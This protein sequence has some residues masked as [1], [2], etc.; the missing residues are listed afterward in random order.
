MQRDT[1]RIPTEALLDGTRVYVFDPD[2]GLIEQREVKTGTAN[3][4]HT[5]V[6]DGL[7]EGER[8]SPSVDREGLADGVTAARDG[9]G[10]MIELTGIERDF[11]VGD[12]P[13]TR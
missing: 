2:S 4:D 12:E 11:A 5:Q 6:T 1:L 9:C 10:Q 7:A 3:W 13:Y 8:S